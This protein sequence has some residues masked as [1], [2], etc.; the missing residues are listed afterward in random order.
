MTSNLLAIDAGPEKS[1]WVLMEDGVPVEWGWDD[2][3][4]VLRMCQ[5]G[6]DIP[7]VIEDITHYGPNISVG[8]DV[9]ET[10]KWM[11]RFQQAHGGEA[12]YISR[13]TIKLHLTGSPRA[14][15]ANIRIALIDRFGGEA[16]AIGG[17]KCKTCKGKGWRGTGRPACGDCHCH[18]EAPYSEGSPKEG[19][20][21]V[22]HPG[23]L[24][25]ISGH[26]FS[27]LAVAVTWM[28]TRGD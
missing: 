2:N 27:A 17:R 18:T 21:Y 23:P 10:C 6:T 22:T 11:G 14:K 1:G 24:H 15:D 4:A 8:R 5:V 20:G 9:F 28:D 7:L 3:F 25:G 26:V 16:V 19:C 12:T 13:P